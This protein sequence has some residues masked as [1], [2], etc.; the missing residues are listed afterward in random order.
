MQNMI[1]EIPLQYLTPNQFKRWTAS[2]GFNGA[3][4]DQFLDDELGDSAEELF[5]NEYHWGKEDISKIDIEIEPETTK[6]WPL[7]PT[8][9]RATKATQATPAT[10]A[11]MM[12]RLDS[13]VVDKLALETRRALHKTPAFQ[14]DS[15]YMVLLSEH[16]ETRL[17][18]NILASEFKVRMAREY[19]C[20]C[21]YKQPDVGCTRGVELWAFASPPPA[22]HTAA[23]WTIGC[24]PLRR[25]REGVGGGYPGDRYTVPNN[26]GT[27]PWW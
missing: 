11:L 4:A 21:L 8:E 14:E 7:L 17:D 27:S 16:W 5:G 15:E 18:E 3:A 22:P 2:V 20:A 19:T 24:V 26:Q 9:T 6:K 13:V 23:T 1:K 12:E 10:P 25:G